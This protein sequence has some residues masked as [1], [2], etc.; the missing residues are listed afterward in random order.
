[1]ETKVGY[2]YN[3]NWLL[4]YNGNG[5]FDAADRVY[6]FP[7]NLGDRAVVGDWNGTHTT[8]TAYTAMASGYSTI[9]ETAPGMA[10]PGV[11]NSRPS[12]AMWARLLSWAIGTAMA[13]R[14]SECTCVASGPWISTATAVPTH[15]TVFALGGQPGEQPIVGAW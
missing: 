4:D 5:V 10:L 14:R 11:T 13:V 2:L 7:Y 3:G 1:M 15:P 12:A 6:S 8:K 9:T